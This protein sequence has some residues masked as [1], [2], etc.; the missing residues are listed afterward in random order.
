MWICGEIFSLPKY[1]GQKMTLFYTDLNSES[2]PLPVAQ[3]G[4]LDQWASFACV[5]EKR[6][7]K[8]A[9]LLLMGPT[10]Y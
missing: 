2:S 9:R 3:P 8:R 7:A 4:F 6:W 10:K 1:V 5:G